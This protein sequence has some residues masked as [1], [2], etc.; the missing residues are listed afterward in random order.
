MLDSTALFLAHNQ[1]AKG[2]S[3]QHN[4]QGDNIDMSNRKRARK[5]ASKNGMEVTQK[6]ILSIYLAAKVAV[7]AASGTFV[8]SEASFS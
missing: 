5:F 1:R 2:V 7:E 3:K 6:H 8:P 4:L